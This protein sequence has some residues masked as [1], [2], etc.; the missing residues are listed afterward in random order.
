MIQSDGNARDLRDEPD[1]VLE[2]GKLK[3]PHQLALVL[4]P[5]GPLQQSEC[6]VIVGQGFHGTGKRPG[7]A[8]AMTPFLRSMAS[9]TLSMAC[10][11]SGRVTSSRDAVA[12]LSF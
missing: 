4:G 9:M 3:R 6:N 1:G 5:M 7:R 10:S 2:P 12:A 11:A 8:Q